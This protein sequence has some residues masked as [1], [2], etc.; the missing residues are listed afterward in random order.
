[1]T[2]REKPQEKSASNV[3][4]YLLFMVS[5]LEL[6]VRLESVSEIVPYEGV[7]TVPGTPAYVRGVLPVRGRVLPVIDLAVKLGRAPETPGKRTCILVVELSGDEGTRSTGIVMDGVATLLDVDERQVAAAPQFGAKVSVQHVQ[8]LIPSA[9]GM[10]PI[11]DV[12]RVFATDE[13]SELSSVAQMSLEHA[14]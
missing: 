7:S 3:R 8:G 4:Q 12:A 14:P 9:R 1:M 6:A 2:H 13:L 11:I 10:V 5:G